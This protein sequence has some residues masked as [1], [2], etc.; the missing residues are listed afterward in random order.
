MSFFS[1]QCDR[2]GGKDHA[3]EDCPHGFFSEACAKCGAKN[4]A[5][6][7]CPHGAFSTECAHCGAIEHATPDCPH[8]LFSSACGKCGNKGHATSD[9]PHGLFLTKCAVCESTGHATDR[10]PHSFLRSNNSRSDDDAPVDAPSDDSS[11]SFE[12]PNTDDFVDTSSSSGSSSWYDDSPRPRPSIRARLNTAIGDFLNALAGVLL[13]CL[14][15]MGALLAMRLVPEHSAVWWIAIGVAVVAGGAAMQKGW[16][17][18]I[19][20]LVVASSTWN[21]QGWPVAGGLVQKTSTIDSSVSTHDSLTKVIQPGP[22]S[23]HD[24]WTTSVY[25][26]AP[27][28]GGPGG[29]ADDDELVVGGFGDSYYTLIR[30]DLEGAPTHAGRATLGLFCFKQRGVGTVGMWLNRVTGSWDWKSTGTGSDHERLWWSDIPSSEKSSATALPPCHLGEWY[31]IDL[32]ALYNAWQ[33]G[34]YENFG[35]ELRP[36]ST[37]NRWSEFYSS[38]VGDHPELRPKLTIQY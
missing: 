30:F 33:D 7:N 20:F 8:G 11:E 17:S 9:C 31:K 5:T 35:I 24:I 29:G 18:A 1:S 36:V 2:C 19:A 13:C 12:S 25:S 32:T 3:V 34:K 37:N 26:Y 28:G 16:L 6:E 22:D 23:G 27:G 10:C 14:V 15:G 4:H 38:Q 21:Y